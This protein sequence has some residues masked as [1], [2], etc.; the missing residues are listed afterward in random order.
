[1]RRDHLGKEFKTDAEMCKHW[2]IRY[3]LYRRRIYD[4][5]LK[6]SALTIPDIKFNAESRTDHL[7]K[8]FKNEKEMCDYWNIAQCTYRARINTL[9]WSKEKAFTT[10]VRKRSPKQ[11][12]TTTDHLG[13]EFE[14]NTEKCKYWKIH[15]DTYHHRKN[16]QNMTEE[17]ALTLRGKRVSLED[18]TDHLGKEFENIL[19]MCNHWNI[20]LHTYLG[21]I[22]GLK[23]PK[24]KALTYKV[25]KTEIVDRT[26]HLGREFKNGEKMC[27]YWKINYKTYRMRIKS[28]WSKEKALTTP[29]R[30]RRSK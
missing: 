19:E 6:E 14:N 10:P 29:V 26:D 5:W 17:Q 21:R 7:G 28:K 15:K 18:R 30:K 13:E 2:N 4:G 24:E 1:M 25:R 16:T 3:E 22:H 23:W 12:G 20:N 9:K 27:E 8:E 11:I